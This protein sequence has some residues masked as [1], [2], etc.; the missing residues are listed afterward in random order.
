MSSLL[1]SLCVFLFLS[2]SAVSSSSVCSLNG[3]DYSGL[4]LFADFMVETT[5]ECNTGNSYD[6]RISLCRPIN[7]TNSVRCNQANSFYCQVPSNNM[8]ATTNA[9]M[10]PLNGTGSPQTN[11][12]LFAGFNTPAKTDKMGLVYIWCPLTPGAPSQPFSPYK[13]STVRVNPTTSNP[14]GSFGNCNLHSISISLPCA[15]SKTGCPANVV[16]E[17]IKMTENNYDDIENMKDL[18]Q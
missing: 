2:V 4:A 5:D 14:Y 10:T 17:Y 13:A 8:A 15:C 11:G 16:S 3:V 12:V 7:A 6:Y 1:L 18:Y 9:V